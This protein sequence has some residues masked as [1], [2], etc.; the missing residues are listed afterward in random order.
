MIYEHKSHCLKPLLLT[1][2]PESEKGKRKKSFEI[3]SPR[4]FAPDFGKYFTIFKG[5]FNLQGTWFQDLYLDKPGSLFLQIIFVPL[6]KD[7][8]E[9]N[10]FDI[11]GIFFRFYSC[12][13]PHV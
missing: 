6:A 11:Q 3:T 13:S 8:T 9:P 2:L 4:N 10:C 1:N 12:K 7:P 5:Q